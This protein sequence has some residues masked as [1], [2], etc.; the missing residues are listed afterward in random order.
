M[1]VAAL[2]QLLRATPGTPEVVREKMAQMDPRELVR[3]CARHGLSALARHQ[4]DQ[5]GIALPP[6]DAA[7]LKRH[8]ISIAANALKVKG[9]LLRVLDSL[10]QHGVTPVLLKGYGLA[11]R[12]Y[13]DPL[14]RPMTD[15]D[16]LIS[17]GEMAAAT[18][19]LGQAGLSTQD[20]GL[21]RYSRAHAHHLTFFGAAVGV[22]LHFAAIKDLGSSIEADALLDRALDGTLDGR[23]VRYLRPEDEVA[24]LSTHATHHLMRGA[25]WLYD[26]KL[27]LRKHPDLEWA[28]VLALAK[29]SEMQSAVYFALKA[30]RDLLGAEVPDSALD[31]LQPPRWQAA[32]GQMLFSGERLVTAPFAEARFSWAVTPLL[33]SN[34]SNLARATLFVAWRAPLRKFARHFPQ[35]AP[36]HWR[37]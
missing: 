18:G 23:R 29:E 2:A 4:L 36:R 33:A 5:A 19:A 37:S 32:L 24:Y 7:E 15:V 26:I 14:L 17:P 21:E 6:D 30:A 13:P 34:L 22:E 25:A 9:V 11:S 20:A 1:I 27:L 28:A 12:F 3:D 16:L 31:S 35:L 8:A 10:G